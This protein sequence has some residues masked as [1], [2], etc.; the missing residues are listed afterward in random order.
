M[1]TTNDVYDSLNPFKSSASIRGWLALTYSE[2]CAPSKGDPNRRFRTLLCPR[3]TQRG[4][5][6]LRTVKIRIPFQTRCVCERHSKDGSR[7][8]NWVGQ[9]LNA[10]DILDDLSCIS[11]SAVLEDCQQEVAKAVHEKNGQ[12][13]L[14]LSYI[15]SS[16][17]ILVSTMQEATS[18]QTPPPAFRLPPRDIEVQLTP[19]DN[20][21]TGNGTFTSRRP[22][23]RWRLQRYYDSLR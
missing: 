11:G 12:N 3:R 15:K 8:L 20:R 14:D 9:Q 2:G 22:G 21:I 16:Y 23:N 13:Y 10:G 6:C 5:I 18:E 4:S 1:P 17:P 7:R 19:Q